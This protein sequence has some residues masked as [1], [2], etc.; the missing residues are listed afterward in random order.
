MKKRFT[1][2]LLVIGMVCTMLAGCSKKPTMK[3]FLPGEY[4]GEGVIEG[5]EKEYGCK[6]IVE[7]FD[8]NEMMYTKI[9]AGDAYDVLI[10][11]DYMIE[12]LLKEDSLQPLNKAAL[13]NL[14]NL[15]DE[16]KNLSFD[17]DNTYAVPY[18]WGNVGIVYVKSNVDLA[19]LE[20]DNYGI[21][22]NEK[23][24]GR[25]FVYDSERDMFMV[26]LKQLGYSCNTNNETEIQEAY[27]WLVQVGKTMKPVY[28][29]DEVI[30]NM[31]HE[32]L[33]L[34]VMYS[35]DAAYI[36]SENENLGYYVPTCGTNI[37]YDCM[38][39]PKNAENPDLANKFINYMLTY[40]AA[41]A[42][43]QGVGYTSPVK[44]VLDDAYGAGG[45]YEGNEA[46][47]PRAGYEFDEPFQD[48]E[49]LRTR[50]SELWIKVKAN[51]AN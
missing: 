18:F 10:P 23:Y 19:D 8:S 30:D 38:V 33:D 39:I 2:M 35:G 49:Y 6:V 44:A 34:A 45:D 43:T 28:V 9:S 36:T 20:N 4:L 15:A 26:A 24:K 5:F 31:L 51:S 21:F 17:S 50:L 42:N 12:R 29:T 3:L 48:N 47:Y 37:W 46:Y 32:D 41:M 40:D 27:D 25:I 13:T 14:G 22:Q 1:V 16:V 11:S 7:T